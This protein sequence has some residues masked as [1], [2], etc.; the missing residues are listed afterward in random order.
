MTRSWPAGQGPHLHPLLRPT[1][2]L[3]FPLI[4]LGLMWFFLVRPQQQRVRRQRELVAS[5]VLG[6]EVV[7]AGGVVG[8][9]VALDDQQARLEIAPGV[10][11]RFLRH[12]VN[13]RIGGPGAVA[14]EEEA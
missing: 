7:T 4:F 12:A 6:D 1:V 8:T 11:V 5:L 3:L 14:D 10:E 9:I 13:G 2:E